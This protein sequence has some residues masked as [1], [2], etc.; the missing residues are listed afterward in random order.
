[1]LQLTAALEISDVKYQLSSYLP[2]QV[3]LTTAKICQQ[4][5]SNRWIKL[6]FCLSCS[7]SGTSVYFQI[8]LELYSYNFLQICLLP[9]F[10]VMFQV[11]QLKQQHLFLREK[12]FE[13]MVLKIGACQITPNEFIICQIYLCEINDLLLHMLKIYSYIQNISTGRIVQC[14]YETIILYLQKSYVSETFNHFYI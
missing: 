14:R 1:M 3:N 10:E 12:K 7:F 4:H 2:S 6:L 9:L 11:S 5:F 8:L 13:I